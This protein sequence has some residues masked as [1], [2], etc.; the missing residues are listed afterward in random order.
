M[1]APCP[2][3][4]GWLEVCQ[5]PSGSS[6]WFWAGC[7]HSFL[8]HFYHWC[9][10]TW[11]GMTLA[12]STWAFALVETVHIVGLTLLLGSALVLDLSILGVG[13]K[14]PADLAKDVMPYLLMGLVV[15]L[16]TGIPMFMSSASYYA[17]NPAFKIK[18]CMLV[19]A[20]VLQL[21]VAKIPGMY[22][23]RL[24]GKVTALIA[25]LSWFTVAYAGRAIAFTNLFGS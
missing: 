6:L 24:L 25:I 13:L 23:G 18:M 9:S 11:I 20:M 1:P 17:P 2:G 10:H 21:G 19:V 5:S 4:L 8:P 3:K 22:G 12:K 15:M 14:K 7:M 16:S